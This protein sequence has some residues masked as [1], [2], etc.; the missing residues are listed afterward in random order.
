MTVKHLRKFMP[1]E[2]R[3]IILNP[4]ILEELLKHR[5]QQD[6]EIPIRQSD[7]ESGEVFLFL[8]VT[9]IFILNHCKI[10]LSLTISDFY[11]IIKCLI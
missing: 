1:G 7:R 5:I 6:T 3:H 8:S 10:N 9:F 4:E 2:I 11:Y